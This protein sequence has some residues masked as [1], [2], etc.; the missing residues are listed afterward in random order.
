MTKAIV[1]QKL[2]DQVG[3][4]PHLGQK[5]VHR[6]SERFRIAAWGRRGGKSQAGGMELLPAAYLTYFQREALRSAMKRHEYWIVGPEYSDSEKEFRVIWNALKARGFD[7]DKPGSYNNPEGG[8]MSIS[9]FDGLYQVHA[10]SAKYPGT[11]VGEGLMGLVLSEA[12][13]LKRVVWEKYL[14]PTLADYRGWLYAGSTPEGK[15][16]FYELWQRGQDPQFEEYWSLRAPSWINPHVYPGGASMPKINALRQA[17]ER[18]D[19]AAAVAAMQ[20]DP[21]IVSLMTGM[22]DELFNQEIAALFTDFVGRVFKDFE[23]ETHVTRTPWQYSATEVPRQLFAAVDYGW[24]NPFVWLLLE[25]DHW[26]AVYVKGELYEP[27]LT[28][29]DAADLILERGLAPPGLKTF[30]PDPASPGDSATL[31][32]RLRLTA[33]GGTGGELKDRLELIRRAL[34]RPKGLEHLPY[35]HPERR[36]R[37]LFSPDCPRTIADFLNYRYPDVGEKIVNRPEV[38]LKK[39]DHGPEALGRFYAGYF[40]GTERAAARVRRANMRG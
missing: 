26:G 33:A 22:S 37:L 5:A 30:F 9:L 8:L 24:T 1:K 17:R 10:K 16:W 19:L 4:H 23:E 3:Y 11:L 6:A 18:G 40:G 21:E 20:I 28:P 31:A 25:V 12:A 32:R 39:D 2:W 36:P 35:D 38:P 7:F 14:R 15:N 34:R 29:D 27:G 13:K